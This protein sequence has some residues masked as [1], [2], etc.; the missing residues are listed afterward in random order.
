MVGVVG[1]LGW[2]G[3]VYPI[4]LYCLHSLQLLISGEYLLEVSFES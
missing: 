4:V 1:P 2:F 3:I